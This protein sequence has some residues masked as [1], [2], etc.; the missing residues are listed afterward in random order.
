MYYRPGDD[1]SAASRQDPRKLKVFKKG[2]EGKE[3]Q[4]AKGAAK[5]FYRDEL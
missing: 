5:A 4:K 3:A 2:D 1:D